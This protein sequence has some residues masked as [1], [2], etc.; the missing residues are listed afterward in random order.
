MQAY[1]IYVKNKESDLKKLIDE[2]TNKLGDKVAND[3]KM[4][5]LELNEYVLKD[6]A[7]NQGKE[8][9]KLYK[10]IKTANSRL[11]AEKQEKMFYHCIALEN[12]K[13]KKMLKVSLARVTEEY[14][15]LK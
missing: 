9:V 8:I 11:E 2:I 13:Q 12:K 7:V 15:L 14:E 5:R 10:E 1:N 6:K 4:K 3:K